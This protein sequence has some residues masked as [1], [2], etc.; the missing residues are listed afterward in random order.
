MFINIVGDTL[1]DLGN[2]KIIVGDLILNHA[3]GIR[4]LSKIKEVNGTVYI[5]NC[6][7]LEDLGD[8]RYIFGDINLQ[9]TS[10]TSLGKL[11]NVGNIRLENSKVEDLGQL[12]NV[13]GVLRMKGTKIKNLGKIERIKSFLDISY[14]DI[15]EVGPYLQSV[16]TIYCSTQEQVES[17]K[18]SCDGKFS[19]GIRG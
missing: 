17:I 6:Y 15:M 7:N 16:Q 18:K 8:L 13:R 4:S 3:D 1:T 11:S 2:L 5:L 12:K 9:E 19:V 14:T 10:V